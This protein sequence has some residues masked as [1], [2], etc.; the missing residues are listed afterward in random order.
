MIGPFQKA[1]LDSLAPLRTLPHMAR[2]ESYW[3]PYSTP[4][5]RMVADGG[6]RTYAILDFNVPFDRV[7]SYLPTVRHALHV[8]GLSTIL[9]GDP[10]IYDDMEQVSTQDLHTV[11]MFTFPI[12]LVLLA[13]I[14]GTLVA[15]AVPV[16]LGGVSV[17]TTLAVLDVLAQRIDMSIFVLNV[18]T[19]IGL[20]I[21][22]DYSLFMVNRFRQEITRHSLED[23]VAATMA[24]A[25]RAVVFSGFTVMLGLM[26]LLV[27]KAMALRSLGIGGALVV[28]VS[29]IA[30]LT[31]L[32]ALLSVLGTRINALPV[33]PRR[34]QGG[35][36]FWPGLARWVMRRP[37]PIIA[38]ALVLIA[39]VASPA[40][41]LQLS[42][43]DATILPTSVASRQGYD[44]LVN[45]FHTTQDTPIIIV[46]HGHGPI[47]T[48][49]NIDTIYDYTRRVT[50]LRDV[51]SIQS[52]VNLEPWLTRA[53]YAQLPVEVANPEVAARVNALTGTQATLVMVNPRPGLSENAAD[54]LVRRIRQ[55]PLGNGSLQ[56]EVGGLTAGKMDYI[57][58]LYADFPKTVLFVVGMTY[59]VLLVL[60]RSVVLPLKAVL[61]NA[62]SLAGSFGAIV[63]V[64]QQGHF[65]NLLNFTPTGS[66]DEINPILMFCTLFG[67]SMDYEVFLLSRIK[68][69]YEAT[70]D[71]AASVAEGLAQTGRI[72]T[73]AALI[74]VVVAGSFAFTSI[75]LVKSL[76]LGMAIAILIDATIIRCLLVPATMR[77]LGEWNWWLPGTSRRRER[78]RAYAEHH[79]T[80]SSSETDLAMPAPQ[81]K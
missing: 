38:G 9:T 81:T 48:T 53:D 39:V 62:L 66:I 15:S 28:A 60:F 63:F 57:D 76:G 1:V 31:L 37:W 32:P 25:G 67:L 6:H 41:T 35:G 2:I 27:F 22:I 51:A 78:R 33:I 47:L 49:G 65:S 5:A 77:V 7:Q 50:R 11:E 54:D 40:R 30:A 12:A 64:F 74:M 70:G 4:A 24:T 59:L 55:V 19:M 21:G 46:V 8:N 72:I 75:V 68:E 14:F 44:L 26:G 10:A 58:L 56:R 36:E 73:S 20:G 69:H 61:M 18:T 3:A 79:H 45:D 23:A 34:L 43:P 17:V 52:I 29:V 42:I 80:T 13:L 16:V 71:N